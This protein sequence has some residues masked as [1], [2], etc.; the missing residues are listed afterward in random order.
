MLVGVPR[1]IVEGEHRVAVVPETVKKIVERGLDVVV[2][3]GAGEGSHHA[4]DA[5]AAAGAR[6]E[7]SAESVLSDSDIV[8]KVQPPAESPAIGRHEVDAMKSGGLLV[9]FLFAPGGAAEVARRLRDR[10]VTAFAMELMPRITRAQSMDALSS[11]S[12]I[13]GY[14]AV[15]IAAAALPRYF[16]MLMTAA[17]TITPARV[18]V[19]GAGVAG[20]QAIATAK[21]LGAVVEAY[22]VRPVVKEQVESL[23]GRFVQLEVETGDAEGAGGYAKEQTAETQERIRKLLFDHIRKSDVVITTAL[24]PGK[25][26]PRIV[27]T[28]A[29]AAMRSGSVIVDLAAEQGGNCELTRAGETVVEH[30]VTIIGPRNLPSSMS[31]HAS[32][33]YSRNVSTFLFHLVN[34]DGELALDLDDEL[35]RAPLVTRNGEVLHEP[36]R[37]L[38][39]DATRNQE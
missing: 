4:D 35:T 7:S 24:V 14:K 16:P 39:D 20:L 12:N 23:G 2:E 38:L 19:I 17:G 22:D 26:A 1:E 29:V 33:L 34:K 30:G 36:T 25:P 10:G 11:M 18:L 8:L 9:S 31:V 37:Q 6:V 5:Y 28:D 13:A 15:L 32:Q 21:R 3:A 27:E